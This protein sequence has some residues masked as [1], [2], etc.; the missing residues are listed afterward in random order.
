MVNGLGQGRAG[1]MAS[2]SA[3]W[4]ESDRRVPGT[5]KLKRCEPKERR[6]SPATAGSWNAILYAV[7]GW[8]GVVFDGTDE[9]PAAKAAILDGLLSGA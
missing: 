8:R 1:R 7:F 9:W 5:P 3:D 6:E 4:K 2:A